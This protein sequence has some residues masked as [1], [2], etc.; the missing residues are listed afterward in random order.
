MFDFFEQPK[1]ANKKHSDNINK[2]FVFIS[3]LL[4]GDLIGDRIPFHLI[5]EGQYL[6]Y[7]CFLEDLDDAGLFHIGLD[8]FYSA[9]DPGRQVLTAILG[10]QDSILHPHP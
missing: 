8:F 7:F 10:N 1:A 2:R 6:I 4:I 5:P 9:R 3:I